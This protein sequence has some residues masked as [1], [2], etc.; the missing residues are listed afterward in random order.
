MP[1]TIVATSFAV[2]VAVAVVF[3]ACRSDDVRASAKQPVIVGWV[4]NGWI[5]EPAIR[6]RVKLDSGAKTSSISAPAYRPFNQGGI[7]YVRFT[8]A[9]R[10]GGT[11]DI[12]RPVIRR[13]TIRRAGAPQQTR[14]VIRLKL[15]LAGRRSETEF[16]LVDRSDMT[17]PVLIGRSFLSGRILIDPGKTFLASGRCGL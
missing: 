11:I 12:E 14:P 9:N 15:C 5:G 10:D 2:F 1:S 17:Y 13:V 3:G 8:L 4:E 16:T 6:F 7:D